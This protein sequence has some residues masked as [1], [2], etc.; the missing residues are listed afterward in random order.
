[1]NAADPDPFDL[2]RFTAAQDA[3]ETYDR[4]V[5][6]LRSGRKTG[7]WMWFAFPQIAGLG[8]SLAS[9]RYAIRSLPEARAY[10]MHPVLGPRLTGWSL[11]LTQAGGL[12]AEQIFG[13]IDATKLR[14]SMTLFRHA[15]PGQPLFGRVLDQDF[16]GQPDPLSDGGV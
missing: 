15:D 12:T 4:A 2:D 7:H 5:A 8:F 6:E 14:L 13:G 9:R 10:L 1:M 16:G 11:I 3:G